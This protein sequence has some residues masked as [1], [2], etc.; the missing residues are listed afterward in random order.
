MSVATTV[1]TDFKKAPDEIDRVLRTCI[2]EK[3]PVYLEVRN[4][5]WSQPCDK[6]VDSDVPLKPLPLPPEIETDINEIVDVGR[7][8]VINL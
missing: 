7:N 3:R 2:T 1:I 4:K 6:P 8:H 5:V